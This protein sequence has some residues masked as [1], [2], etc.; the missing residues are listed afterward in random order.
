MKQKAFTLIELLVVISIMALLAGAVIANYAGR[1][2]PR[3]LKIAQNELVTNIRK[4]QSY[5]LSSR[6]LNGTTPV[7]YY[8]LR[9]DTTSS[10]QY[11]I[12]AM[13]NTQSSPAMLQKAETINLPTGVIL[14]SPRIN[15]SASACVLIAFQLPYAK[16]LNNSSC[17]GAPPTVNSSDDYQKIISFVAN[18]AATTV[19]S[20]SAVVLTLQNNSG[21]AYVLVN[22]IT[23][24]VCPT[25]NAS[26]NTCLTTY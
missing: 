12:Q 11:Q 4:A 23:G 10:T 21:A 22:G 14:G 3:D 15:G 26:S 18:N 20:D 2:S 13:Y 1:R 19:T 8:V 16:I 25:A 9:F 5:A 7:Q 17:A 24:V 6:E